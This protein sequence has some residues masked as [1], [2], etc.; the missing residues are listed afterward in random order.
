MQLRQYHAHRA[1]KVTI[2]GRDTPELSVRANDRG[3]WLQ[4]PRI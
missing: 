2:E 4:G 3:P 1:W